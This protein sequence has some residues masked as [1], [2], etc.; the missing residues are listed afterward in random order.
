MAFLMVDLSD[1]RGIRVDGLTSAREHLARVLIGHDDE[2]GAI[3]SVLG[4][5]T[6]NVIKP[7]NHWQF[8]FGIIESTPEFDAPQYINDGAQTQRF[9]T[10]ANRTTVRDIVCLVA[11]A[12][13]EA[14][15]PDTITFMTV[16]D[17]LP[18]KALT[19]YSHICK[20][21]REVGY[22]GGRGNEF[23]GNHIWMMI[24]RSAEP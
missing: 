10:G 19:K 9:L 8:E 21:L 18:A 5:L 16:V 20:A 11:V 1:P 3:Y 6:P 4:S 13:A 24:R 23:H 7:G 22:S 15:K 14:V 12:L 17:H 2:T